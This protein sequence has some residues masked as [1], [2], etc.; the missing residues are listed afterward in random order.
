MVVIQGV[1]VGQMSGKR[2]TVRFIWKQ[3]SFL[4]SNEVNDNGGFV[5]IR[6]RLCRVRGGGADGPGGSNLDLARSILGGT[7]KGTPGGSTVGG[8]Y[9]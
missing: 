3:W 2:G 7:P 9:G 4:V 8:G 5:C 1:G 6:S